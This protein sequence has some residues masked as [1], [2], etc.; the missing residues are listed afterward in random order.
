MNA[1]SYLASVTG[2]L[3]RMDPAPVDAIADRLFDA[4]RSGRRVFVFGNG[5]SAA[6]ASHMA[7]DLAKGTATDLGTGP[8]AAA[9]PRLKVVSLADN[10]ALLTAVGNDLA[11]EDVFLEPLKDLLEPGDVV[12]GISGSGTSPNVL[13]AL[14]YARSAGAVTL[15]LTGARPSGERMAALCDVCLRASSELMETIEDLHVV[16]HHAIALA[17]RD[18]IRA[19]QGA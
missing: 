5:A 18:R 6:L 11:Y 2:C 9:K 1:A 14:Q 3:G 17:L 15:G 19:D 4:Y 13:R 12:L 7:A 10:L 8:G 16:A